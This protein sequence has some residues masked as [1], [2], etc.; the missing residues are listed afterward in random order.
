MVEW[1]P[2]L[3]AV[4]RIL[5]VVLRAARIDKLLG[6]VVQVYLAR[7]VLRSF[8]VCLR[9]SQ[10][11]VALR[12]RVALVVTFLRHLA[13]DCHIFAHHGP[14]IIIVKVGDRRSL[15]E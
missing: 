10:H 13:V 5:S 9:M 8:S 1:T 4:I 3:A 2:L 11:L 15:I 6:H 7:A 12:Q 14:I